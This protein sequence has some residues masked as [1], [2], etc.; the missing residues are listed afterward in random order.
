MRRTREELEAE[1]ARI[2]Q[3]L[4]SGVREQLSA[5]PGVVHVTVGL[6]QVGG[7]A[8]DEF[9]IKVYVEQKL[10]LAQLTPE[11][12]VPAMVAG[13]P[14][15]VCPVPT[16]SAFST[17]AGG[18]QITNGIAVKGNQPGQFKTEAGTLGFVGLRNDKDSTPVM[19]SNAHVMGA[20]G[21]RVGDTIFQPQP[22]PDQISDSDTFPRRP[23]T[24]VNSVG[25]VVD[26]ELNS[27]I[28]DCA[29]AAV[30]TCY[31]C[32][33]SCGT[34]YSHEITGLKVNGSDGIAGVAPAVPGLDVVKV[35]RTTGRTKGTIV[36]TDVPVSL[37]DFMGSPRTFTG[38]IEISGDSGVLFSDHGD[39]GSLIV[40]INGL[41]VGLL[42]AGQD[43]SPG[44]DP[45]EFSTFANHIADVL[46]VM[47]IRLPATAGQQAAALMGFRSEQ[48]T[49]PLEAPGFLDELTER[50]DR[51][52][53]GRRLR[54]AIDRQ[55]REVVQ[56]VN[57]RRRV[58][59][60][61]HR[62]QGQAWLAAFARSA[63]HPDFR[64][65][66]EIDGV[67]RVGA[68]FRLHAALLVEGSDELQADLR[69]LPPF[70][71]PALATC[72]T[73]GQLLGL[74]EQEHTPAT[75]DQ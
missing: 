2:E 38:Q 26:I 12:V 5:L 19:L 70:L 72:E 37:N 29:I 35:G 31:S 30:S 40:G 13:V 4:D 63:R 21:G 39:S 14:S 64:L 23:T 10:P 3:I 24:S 62:G 73:V 74:L 11:H 60:A 58:T 47:K 9:S 18:M 22:G 53:R 42:F 55:G 36:G 49:T 7:H 33:C 32:C 1:T 8:T 54:A 41:A 52:A 71:L 56:L 50:L 25:T 65:P 68:V 6:K 66:D 59:V 46:T 16:A 15:D 17:V 67:T 45:S 48:V 51:S 20:H 61:W 69:D 43:P 75:A 57:H 28:V 44:P 34:G 27:T